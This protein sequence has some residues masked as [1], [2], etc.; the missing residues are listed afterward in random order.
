MLGVIGILLMA[1]GASVFV[2]AARLP[3]GSGRLVGGNSPITRDP[4]ALDIRARNSPSVVADPKNPEHLA[5]AARVDSPRFSCVLHLST[6]G[7]ARWVEAATPSET[8]GVACFAP[9]ASFGGDGRLYFT[10]TSFGMVEGGGRVPNAVWVVTSSD[11]G[12]TFEPPQ[13]ASGPLAFNVRLT[14]DPARAKRV[15]L[16]WVQAS[17][18][19]GFGFTGVGN[20][21]V[22]SRS[23]DGGQTWA[24]PREVSNPK[25]LRVVAPAMATGPDG[26]LYAAYLDVGGDVLDYSGAHE[27][28]GGDPY[29]GKWS[30]V[31]ARSSDDGETWSESV[32]DAGVVPSRRFLALFPPSPS[33][34]VD[35]R[36]GKLYIGFQDARRGDADVVVWSSPDGRRWSSPRRVNDS[37][38]SDGTS[39]Y[40]PA[41]GVAPDGRLDVVYYDRRRDSRD[42][43]NEVSLQSS[44]DGGVSFERRLVISDRAFD[45]EIGFGS[46]RGLVEM[47]SRLGLLSTREGALA[48]WADTRAGTRETAKQDLARALVAVDGPSALKEYAPLIG[49]ALV[50]VGAVATTVGARRHRR[51]RRRSQP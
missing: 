12:R 21:V 1:S 26:T 41:L 36:S 31:V 46:D 23:D 35:Q 7:G 27:G 20:P 10:Y 29:A 45:S 34:A 3:E 30:I 33:I 8:E 50:G 9:D 39:Q 11:G 43:M 13:Q 37:K 28:R 17:G 44:F 32:V 40:L 5:I 6:D 15:Y 25:R 24:K 14:A 18:A 38:A 19:A 42:R 2:V 48:V 22:V 49:G 16:S 47:G 4:N 51:H